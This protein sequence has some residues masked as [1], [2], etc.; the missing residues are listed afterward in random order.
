MG[1]LRNVSKWLILGV[2]VLDVLIVM[3]GI[4]LYNHFSICF[5]K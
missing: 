4:Y 1:N 2:I 3:S 5:I